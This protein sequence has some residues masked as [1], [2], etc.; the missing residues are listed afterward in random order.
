MQGFLTSQLAAEITTIV[1]FVASLGLA[2]VMS[3][4]YAKKQSKPLLWWSIG[5]WIFALGVL[6]EIFF[7][8]GSVSQLLVSIYL[9][10]V[11]LIVEALAMGSMQLVKSKKIRN[12]Y[13]VFAAASSL[14]LIYSVAAAPSPNVII[15]YVAGGPPSLP[16]ILA[17]SLITFPA[18]V[19]LV[20]VAYLGYRQRHDKRLLSI[21]AGVVVV[22]VAGT[23]YI[24]QYPA[25][26]YLSEV[27]GIGLLW[28][29]F[30]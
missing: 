16:V 28:Y 26:L 9:L 7:A 15:S 5:M 3:F 8:F 2:A 23:L 11:A 24:V 17:S 4:K 29:G 14:L 13:Y 30:L 27:I 21:I 6:L 12:S 25:L 19:I 22:S 10:V 18:A 1:V 20:V